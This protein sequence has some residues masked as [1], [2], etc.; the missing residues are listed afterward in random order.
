MQRIALTKRSAD[1]DQ[2]RHIL[3]ARHQLRIVPGLT[4]RMRDTRDISAVGP[5][6]RFAAM[7]QSVGYRGH[8]G[9]WQAVRPARLWAHGLAP[10]HTPGAALAAPQNGPGF[11]WFV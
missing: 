4:H 5:S 6:R 9:L 1:L 11:A 8:S 2:P 3:D 7:Q 10:S